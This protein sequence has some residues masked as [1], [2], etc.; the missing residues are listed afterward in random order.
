MGDLG[1]RDWLLEWIGLV[2]SARVA[3]SCACRGPQT[4]SGDRSG[5]E[6][7]F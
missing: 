2:A 5:P 4:E 7:R 6:V 3:L 1:V